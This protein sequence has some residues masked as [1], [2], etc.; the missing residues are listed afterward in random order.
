LAALGVKELKDASSL[1][2]MLWCVFM[3]WSPH[4]VEQGG[5]QGGLATSRQYGNALLVRRRRRGGGG[6]GSG[7]RCN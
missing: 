4:G 2:E 7:E 6:G 1:N 5:G 3:D